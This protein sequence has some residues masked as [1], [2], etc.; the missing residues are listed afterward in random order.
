VMIRRAR[1][2]LG[3]LGVLL[4]APFG[5]AHSQTDSDL[6][7]RGVRA[8]QNVEFEVAATLLRRALAENLAP[9]ERV[10]ALAYLGAA[11][12]FRGGTGTRR[13]SAVAAFRRLL[14]LDPRQRPDRL[15]F[16]PQVVSVFEEVRRA[17]KAVRAVAPAEARFSP[18]PGG[19]WF[20]V[21]L[22]GTSF[23]EVE[24]RLARDDGTVVRTLYVGPMGDSVDVRWDG[25]DTAGAFVPS[26][27]YLLTVASRLSPGS[28][29]LRV[30]QLPLQTELVVPDTLAVPPPPV[31]SLL[32]PERATRGMGVRSLAGGLLAAGA[33]IALPPLVADGADASGIR[34]AVAGAVSFSGLVG[35]VTQRPGRPLP[36]NI[37]ANQARRDFWRRRAEAAQT[38]NAARRREARLTVRVGEPVVMGGERP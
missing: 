22:F 10:R 7:G 33:V 8:Y 2:G 32:L 25:L 38:E 11:E 26:G 36:G 16:P 9:A 21:K 15:V 34:F 18:G 28:P 12:V 20:L 6:V 35:L 4:A 14:L 30:V 1:L 31:D 27:R 3:A 24:A 37:A 29:V 13:D 23:H 19:G 17:T 5:I